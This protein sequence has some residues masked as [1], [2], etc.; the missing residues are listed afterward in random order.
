MDADGDA[1][2]LAGSAGAAAMEVTSVTLTDSLATVPTT[3][4]A[5]QLAHP[6]PPAKRLRV[7]DDGVGSVSS[8][9]LQQLLLQTNSR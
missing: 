3:N 4:G 9:T 7:D 6:A 8:A 5:D 1:G 2:Q